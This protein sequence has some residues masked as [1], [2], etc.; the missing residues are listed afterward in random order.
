MADYVVTKSGRKYPFH[1]FRGSVEMHLSGSGIPC[2]RMLADEWPKEF[3]RAL[4]SAGY[5][6]R[7]ELQ[8]AVYRGGPDGARWKPLSRPHALRLIDDYKKLPREPRTHPFGRLV[9]AIGYRY[10]DA[11]MSVHV[12]WLSHQSSRSGR[13]VQDGESIHVTPKMRRFFWALGIP[14]KK[15]TSVFQTPRRDLFVP[16]LRASEA[17]LLRYVEQHVHAHALKTTRRFAWA[18]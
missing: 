16:V 18:A 3:A 6:L 7:K 17:K 11:T 13:Q 4:K 15:R 5:H 2:L 1:E 10:D 12:G 14:V 8:D 9:R